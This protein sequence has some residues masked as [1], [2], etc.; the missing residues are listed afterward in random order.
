M[1]AVVFW[2]YFLVAHPPASKEP[3]TMQVVAR[4][5]FIVSVTS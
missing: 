5:A 1:G 2:T 4:K 3:V